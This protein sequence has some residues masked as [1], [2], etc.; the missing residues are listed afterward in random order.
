MMYVCTAEP[1]YNEPLY[2]DVLGITN[3]FL[4]PSNSKIYGKVPR[5]NET[6]LWRTKIAS[7]LTFVVSR[8]H[9]MHV[10]VLEV[11]NESAR[12]WQKNF[13][14]YNNGIKNYYHHMGESIVLFF[15]IGHL[16]ASY[17]PFKLSPYFTE[18]WFEGFQFKTNFVKRFLKK[19]GNQYTHQG[20]SFLCA[21]THMRT[22]KNRSRVREE[23]TPTHTPSQRKNKAKKQK[24]KVKTKKFKRSSRSQL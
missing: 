24:V 10:C 19:A 2:N 15:W 6:S 4:Y 17:L 18:F 8:C 21:S 9:C 3:N 23:N 14:L 16:S 11:T 22:S 20:C 5:Y 7:P 1:R 12:C 13:Q